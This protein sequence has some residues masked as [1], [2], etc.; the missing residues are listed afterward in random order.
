[1]D[2]K[3]ILNIAEADLRRIARKKALIL[4][5]L[6]ILA[7]L[8]VSLIARI[9]GKS[10]ALAGV[11]GVER[12]WA[13]FMAAKMPNPLLSSVSLA[14]WSWL[15]AVAF[16]G[17]LLA[18][19]I[20]EATA[21]L[22]VTRATR[23][24]YLLGKLV[25]IT[26]F[27]LIVTLSSATSAVLSA[28]VLAG[29][30]D[31]VWLAYAMA[32]AMAVGLLPLTLLS[33]LAGA[34]LRSVLAGILLGFIAYQACGAVIAVAGMYYARGDLGGMIE[35]QAKYEPLIPITAPMSLHIVLYSHVTGEPYLSGIGAVA[36]SPVEV[37]PSLLA[38][39]ASTIIG[40]LLLLIILW[41]YFRR[42]NL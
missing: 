38:Y 10:E 4:V 14:A 7:P 1:M 11:P 37:H 27:Y 17:D 26:V 36:G 8:I 16:G 9:Q 33:A 41:L 18:S 21:R 20:K 13:V 19:D 2:P 29:R 30:Q 24:E 22:Y 39:T 42:A 25:A 28:W 3:V 5:L 32:V 34:A 23:G 12:L 35:F 40:V 15:V 31:L 6:L